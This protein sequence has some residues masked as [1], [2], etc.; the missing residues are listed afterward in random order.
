MPVTSL[1][2]FAR[3]VGK[4][5][6]IGSAF[7][8]AG[9]AFALTNIAIV[10]YGRNHWLPDGRWVLLVVYTT[11]LIGGLVHQFSLSW[12]RY[13]FWLWLLVLLVAHSAIYTYVLSVVDAWRAI[14]F[15]PLTIIE[16]AGATFLL[17]QLAYDRRPSRR[18]Q[19]TRQGPR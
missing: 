17:Q 4:G 6:L 3:L 10:E 19:R 7:I 12:R 16:G 2:G 11:L 5:V 14:W 18:R 13:D 8:L 1:P 15:L 9:L